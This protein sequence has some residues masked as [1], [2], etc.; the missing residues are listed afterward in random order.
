MT[1]LFVQPINMDAPGSH[2]ERRRV[3]KALAKYSELQKSRDIGL[4]AQAWDELEALLPHYLATDDG[5]PVMDA[6]EQISGNDFDR[7][8]IGLLGTDVAVPEAKSAS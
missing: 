2:K 3:I 4:L 1:K 5:M 7:L 8:S 6:F